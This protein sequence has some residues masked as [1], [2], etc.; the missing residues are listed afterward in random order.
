MPVRDFA[1]HDART[2]T[3]ES[4]ERGG[5]AIAREVDVVPLHVLGQRTRHEV[6]EPRDRAAESYLGDL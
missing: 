2:G 1:V 6:L 3:D 4:G 5:A